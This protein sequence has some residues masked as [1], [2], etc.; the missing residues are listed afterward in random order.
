VFCR[1]KLETPPPKCCGMGR[2]ACLY[3]EALGQEVYLPI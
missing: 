1:R 3:H 2:V